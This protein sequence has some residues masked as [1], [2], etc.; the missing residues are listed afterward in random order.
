[1]QSWGIGSRFTDRHTEAEPTKSGVVGLLSS[2]LGRSREDNI[3]D[4]A[5][6]EMAVRVDREGKITYDYHTTLDV[7]RASAKGKVT[8]SKL[9]T[10]IS[11][12]FYIADACFIV[13]LRGENE[14]LLLELINS[15]NSP[16]YPLFLGRKSFPASMP[17]LLSQELIKDSL[18]EI[19]RSYP[20]QG[21]KCDNPPENLRLILECKPGEG[22]P[23]LDVPVSFKSRKFINRFVRTE[24]IPF[25]SLMEVD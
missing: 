16:K 9:G 13:G 1:M 19:M 22:E 11:R 25:E 18:I 5:M 21:R 3:E 7:L 10:V 14:S 15:L 6:L 23:R 8:P 4:L 24:F 12:R 20:W 17:I 2:I